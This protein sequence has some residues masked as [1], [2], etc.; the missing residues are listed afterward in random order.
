MEVVRRGGEVARLWCVDGVGCRGAVCGVGYRTC[1]RVG[2]ANAVAFCSNDA[3]PNVWG[4]VGCKVLCTITGVS[5]SAGG[6]ATTT[7]GAGATVG[8][9]AAGG[10]ADMVATRA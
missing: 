4:A 2:G 8:E 3:G 6:F 5:G 9:V 10:D 1:G 7:M